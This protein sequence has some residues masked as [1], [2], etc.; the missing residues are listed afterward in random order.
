MRLPCDTKISFELNCFWQVVLAAIGESGAFFSTTF[1]TKT[2]AESETA[3][4]KFAESIGAPTLAALRAKPADELLA[5]TSKGGHAFRFW[6]NIDGYFLPENVRAIYAEGKQAH[7][8][9]LA[10]WN[11]EESGFPPATPE[12]FK[13]Q[14]PK[15]YGD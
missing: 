12:Q 13:E 5:A 6:P 3:G 9:L 4:A 11:R 14:G 7:V 1:N 10:G 8:P 15:T 2:L